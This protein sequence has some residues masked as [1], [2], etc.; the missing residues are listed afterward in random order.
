MCETAEQ[1]LARLQPE[2]G[3]TQYTIDFDSSAGQAFAR[4]AGMRFAP[5]IFIN[6]EPICYGRPSEGKLRRELERR[7]DAPA[8]PLDLAVAPA[9]G[10]SPASA[11]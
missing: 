2:Y 6:L 3:F 8:G 7:R 10:Q 5:G 1:L 4:W 11:P 9:G